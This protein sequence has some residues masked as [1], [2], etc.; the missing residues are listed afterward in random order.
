MKDNRKIQLATVVAGMS[1]GAIL[2]AVIVGSTVMATVYIPPTAQPPEGNMPSTVWNAMTSFNHQ[3]QPE[4]AIN[5]DGGG[6]GDDINGN[7][8]GLPVGI[9]VGSSQL[10]MGKNSGG[11]NV[12]YGVAKKQGMHAEDLLMLLQVYDADVSGYD[13]RFSVDQF[14]NVIVEGDIVT[15]GQ[16][17]STGC[18]GPVFVGI[19]SIG[20]S[21]NLNDLAA[22]KGYF[23]A[24][25]ICAANF[26][27]SHVCLNEEM[28]TS[29]KCADPAA[30]PKPPI[31]D[32]AI[33]P[34]GTFLWVNGG[35]PGHTTPANDCY[36]WTSKTDKHFGR[37][38]KTL[39]GNGGQ[40]YLTTCNQSIKFACCK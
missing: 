28:L 13:D 3:V 33:L 16:I 19:T 8:S 21:G 23:S 14:G 35:V 25:E 6:P 2:A 32:T 27:D 39:A 36:G 18:F 15:P 5:I 4:A 11:Q 30:T 12:I 17:T 10:D 9:S 34:D 37:V 38:W 1:I 26:E 22:N 31:L 29:I 40:G 20:Y 7:P 24:N